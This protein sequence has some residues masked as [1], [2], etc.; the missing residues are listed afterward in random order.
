MTKIPSD[1]VLLEAA[2][3]CKFPNPIEELRYF[4]ENNTLF[5]YNSLC[6]VIAKYEHPDDNRKLMCARKA[7]SLTAW[8]DEPWLN[9]DY[10]DSEEIDTCIEAIR[11]WES[12]YG[13]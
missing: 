3:R 5:A 9:G 11:L 6:D 12:G 7:I 13:A 10:D 8:D 4:Y 2:R 1:M